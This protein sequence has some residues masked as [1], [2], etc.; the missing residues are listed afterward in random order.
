MPLR[1][2]FAT[3]WPV[4]RK[5]SWPAGE[6]SVRRVRV[7]PERYASSPMMPPTIE[8]TMEM[9]IAPRMAEPSESMAMPA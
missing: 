7:R 5:A 2:Q 9:T 6:K 4:E 1:R 8:L 3:L